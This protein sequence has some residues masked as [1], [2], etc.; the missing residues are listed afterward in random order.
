MQ[1]VQ[2]AQPMLQEQQVHKGVFH[3]KF[4]SSHR[5]VSLKKLF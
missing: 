4:T 3:L 5:G 2:Q 1:Q